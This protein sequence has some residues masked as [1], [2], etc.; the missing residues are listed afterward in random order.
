MFTIKKAVSTTVILGA[1]VW[2][3]VTWKGGSE[4]AGNLFLAL[5]LFWFG[6]SFLTLLV[7]G[8]LKAEPPDKGFNLAWRRLV[9]C[10]WLLMAAAL[11]W[12]GHWFM[13]GLIFGQV[14]FVGAARF[15]QNRR[16][17]ASHG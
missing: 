4:G 11:I 6:V 15:D 13:A 9:R 3:F 1:H 17:E 16:W 14:I 8:A 12:F 5:L 2:L 7:S 10:A